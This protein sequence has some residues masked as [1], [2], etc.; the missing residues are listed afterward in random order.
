MARMDGDIDERRKKKFINELK[1]HPNFRPSMLEPPKSQFKEVDLNGNGPITKVHDKTKNA[2]DR[3]PYGD[4][5]KWGPLGG[6][7]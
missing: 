2:W 1:K 5:Y 7:Y 3:G 6:W 4:K